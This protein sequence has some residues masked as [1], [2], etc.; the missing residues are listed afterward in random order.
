ML[1][2]AFVIYKC[3]D[4]YDCKNYIKIAVL[5]WEDNKKQ[6]LIISLR[7]YCIT[8]SETNVMHDLEIRWKVLEAL[9]V[10]TTRP[11]NEGSLLPMLGN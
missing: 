4:T 3:I 8:Y 6:L 11:N 5:D 10:K 7:H 9:F 2:E 1:K